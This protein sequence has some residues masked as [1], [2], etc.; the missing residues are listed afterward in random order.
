MKTPIYFFGGEFTFKFTFCAITSLQSVDSRLIIC[1]IFRFD[2]LL[3]EVDDDDCD[4]FSNKFPL[5]FVKSS[6]LEARW[7]LL[8]DSESNGN[9]DNDD[10]L[11]SEAAPF[12]HGSK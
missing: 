8:T 4:R 7:R 6:K 1:G 12:C 11:L 10:G 5:M 3:R 2:E 9:D